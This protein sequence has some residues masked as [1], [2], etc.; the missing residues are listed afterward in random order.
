ML[1]RVALF[2]NILKTP[3][4]MRLSASTY[5]LQIIEMSTSILMHHTINSIGVRVRAMGLKGL[6]PPP[7]PP[8]LFK[9]VIF[10]HNSK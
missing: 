4:V 3:V 5:R 2:T 8:E 10:G 7:P 1:K 6:Q 9:I